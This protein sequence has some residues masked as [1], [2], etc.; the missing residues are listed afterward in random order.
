MNIVAF[1]SSY[2]LSN[3]KITKEAREEHPREGC[4]VLHL[5]KNDVDVIA[6]EIIY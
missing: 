5:K 4:G 2:R 3:P 1:L 6:T